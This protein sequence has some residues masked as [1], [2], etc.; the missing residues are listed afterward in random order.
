MEHDGYHILLILPLLPHRSQYY[1]HGNNIHTHYHLPSQ[2]ISF[3]ASTYHLQSPIPKLSIHCAT[4]QQH[5]PATTQYIAAT[6]IPELSHLSLY[7]L[8]F[9]FPEDNPTTEVYHMPQKTRTP[10]ILIF[11]SFNKQTFLSSSSRPMI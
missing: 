10:I 7:R 1:P 6:L 4:S 11:L 8:A 9:F 2:I 3:T 5:Q